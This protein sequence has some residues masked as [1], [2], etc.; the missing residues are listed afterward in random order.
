MPLPTGR[1]PVGT[2]VWV[3]HT[4]DDHFFFDQT[5]GVRL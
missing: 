3:I 1:A 4:M 5:R 2:F